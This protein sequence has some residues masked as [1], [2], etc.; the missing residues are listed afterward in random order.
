MVT[1]SRLHK[2]SR[3]TASGVTR[4]AAIANL[5]RSIWWWDRLAIFRRAIDTI[6]FVTRLMVS[7]TPTSSMRRVHGKQ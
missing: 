1:I 4:D 3:I 2:S 5:E 7:A 6:R